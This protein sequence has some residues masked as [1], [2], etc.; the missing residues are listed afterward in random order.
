MLNRQARYE[1]AEATTVKCV[2]VVLEEINGWPKESSLEA[3]KDEQTSELFKR[4]RLH[5]HGAIN[6]AIKANSPTL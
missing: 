5:I 2:R 1:L 4:I 6:K 3:S